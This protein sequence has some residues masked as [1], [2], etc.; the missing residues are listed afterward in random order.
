MGTYTGSRKLSRE[1]AVR[2]RHQSIGTGAGASLTLPS[3]SIL[4]EN[5]RIK[6]NDNKYNK[7]KANTYGWNIYSSLLLT[8][9]C[10]GAFSLFHIFI[11]DNING[12]KKKRVRSHNEI[13]N[14]ANVLSFPKSDKAFIASGEEGSLFSRVYYRANSTHCFRGPKEQRVHPTQSG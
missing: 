14:K 7:K 2:V 6:S 3:P 12:V 11:V 8:L 5:K 13:I 4:D 1:R 10:G 9:V